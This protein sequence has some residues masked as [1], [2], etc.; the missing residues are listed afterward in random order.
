ME[1]ETEIN[2]CGEE[3]GR[4]DMKN[5]KTR[6]AKKTERTALKF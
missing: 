5:D 6:D 3:T 2:Y 1:E 4:I